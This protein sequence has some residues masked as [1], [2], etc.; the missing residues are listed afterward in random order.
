MYN[1]ARTP[2]WS[3]WLQSCVKED[4]LEFVQPRKRMHAHRCS[5]SPKSGNTTPPPPTF[6]TDGRTLPEICLARLDE[7][8]WLQ[9]PNAATGIAPHICS[10]LPQLCNTP[11]VRSTGGSCLPDMRSSAASM[12][13]KESLRPF[14]SYVSHGTEAVVPGAYWV[15]ASEQPATFG[16]KGG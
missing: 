9:S 16:G 12:M 8:V 7:K 4:R 1:G 13:C 10:A 11:Y 15:H 6:F 2:L 5:A 14:A 3:L